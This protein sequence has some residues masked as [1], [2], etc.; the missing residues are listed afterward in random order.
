MVKINILL[1]G[2]HGLVIDGIR[3][4]LE[5]EPDMEVVGAVFSPTELEKEV[6][7]FQ[8]DIMSSMLRAKGKT[9]SFG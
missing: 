5:R 1:I 4:L 7:D 9:T 8:P 3:Q 6:A 2:D